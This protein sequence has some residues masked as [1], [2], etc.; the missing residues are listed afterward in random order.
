MVGLLCIVYCWSDYLV[1]Q[2]DVG[3]VCDF[4][5]MLLQCLNGAFLNTIEEFKVSA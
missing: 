5:K 3:G 1:Y 4:L 2:Y